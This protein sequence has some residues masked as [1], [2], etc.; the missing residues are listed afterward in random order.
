VTL[1]TRGLATLIVLL[2][3]VGAI[4]ALWPGLDL[5]V[6]HLFYDHGGF[7]GSSRAARFGRDFFRM[8][9]FVV[10]A[11][12]A[13]IYLARRYTARLEAWLTHK[14]PRLGPL[15]PAAIRLNRKLASLA[16]APDGR[17]VVFL[18]ASIVIGSGL[19]VNLGMKDHLHRPR[20]VQTVEF[21]GKDEFRPW[22]RFDG[23]CNKNCG[24]PSGEASSGFWMV[25]PAMLTP[26]PFDGLA[27]AAAYA[28]AIGASVLRLAFGGHYLSDVLMGGLISLIVVFS[29]RRLLWRSGAP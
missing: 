13:L 24:F 29:V 14:P 21:G 28:F 16:W 22:Y 8:T 10:L 9:P 15:A 7:I 6:T 12:F 17:A 11:L 18:V 23:G 3:G 19:I 25:A 2:A 20:P 5:A 4:F 1:R 27:L 26:P